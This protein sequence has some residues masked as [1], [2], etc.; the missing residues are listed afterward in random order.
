MTVADL[1]EILDTKDPTALVCA[2]DRGDGS[3]FPVNR[4]EDD[5][6]HSRTRGTHEP[7]ISIY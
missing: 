2:P 6:Y 7:C 3:L 1:K 4:V 5:T